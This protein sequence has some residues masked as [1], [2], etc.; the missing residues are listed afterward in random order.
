VPRLRDLEHDGTEWQ[1]TGDTRNLGR[2]SG[3]D[4]GVRRR[5]NV[6]TYWS[7]SWMF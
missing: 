2:L 7:R 4:A 6:L 3:V 5:R 1:F